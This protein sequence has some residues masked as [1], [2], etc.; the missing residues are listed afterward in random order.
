MDRREL[1]RLVSLHGPLR[2]IRTAASC[3]H[4]QRV[5][6]NWQ[7]N[8]AI[9][10]ALASL[11]RE[12][13]VAGDLTRVTHTSE[14]AEL[15]RAVN[16]TLD[17]ARAFAISDGNP[18]FIL[19]LARAHSSDAADPQRTLEAVISQRAGE[20]EQRGSRASHVG[21]GTGSKLR[22]RHPRGFRSGAIFRTPDRALHELERRGVL[23]PTAENTYDFVHDVVR[24][25]AYHDISQPRRKLLHARIARSP[26]LPGRGGSHSRERCRPPCRD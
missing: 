8:P 17:P 15:I 16:S 11:R 20:T 18:L 2:V 5:P 23:H 14:T 24:Q 9:A 1:R 6:V 25:V 19:E 13:K 12:R 3:S 21:G 26:Q 4:A 7:D 22:C 10:N